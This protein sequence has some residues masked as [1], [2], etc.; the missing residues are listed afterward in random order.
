MKRPSRAILALTKRR[1]TAAL[2]AV[3]CVAACLVM[4][5]TAAAP[6]S[7]SPG[8]AHPARL[9]RAGHAA[10]VRPASAAQARPG[11]AGAWVA[12]DGSPG[13]PAV[14][15]ST[16]TLYVP[17]QC[18]ANHCM[19]STPAHVVD[20]VST[21][22]CNVKV[23]S[24]C[25][26]VA[27]ARVGTGPGA[28]VVDGG[29]DTVYVTNGNSNTVSVLNGAL[30]N[31]TVT[32][33]CGKPVATVKVGQFPV[34][35]VLNPVTGTV[36]VAS[37][38]GN[39]FVIDAAR[40]NAHTTSGCGQ[41]VKTVKVRPGAQALDVDVATNTVY[42]ANNGASGNGDT[43]SMIDGS[44][45]NGHDGR[46]CG[47][48]PHTVKVGSGAFWVAVDQASH[49]VYVANF[50]NGFNQGSVSVID[51]ARCNA[52]ITSGCRRIPPAVPT[53]IAASFVAVDS[54]LHTVFAVNHADNTLS[55]I[56]IR[57]CNGKV[58]S[59][60]RQRPPSQQISPDQGPGF[61]FFPNALALL[62]RTGTAYTM[63]V[64]GS[65]VLDVL[66]ISRCNAINTSGC[67]AEAPSVAGH[68][69][70]L[71]VDPATDTI[72]AG[73]LSRPRIDVLNGATCQHARLGGCVPVAAIPMGHPQANVG[74]IDPATHTLYASDP[75]SGT[76]SVINTANCN[77]IQTVG[78]AAQPPVIN[79][80]PFPNP[81]IVNPATQTLYVSYGSNA[82]RVAVVNAATCN[83]TR[84][85]GCGQTPAVVKV[86]KGTFNLAAS[87]AT[88]TIYAPNT[89]LDFDGDTVSVINGAACNGTDHSGCDHLAAV[90][91]AG[92]GPLGVTVNDR[93]HTVYVANNAHGYSPGTVS[94]INGA[95]CNGT[96]TAG[97]GRH[98]STMPTGPGPLFAA[99]DT[100]TGL[101]F[102][103]DFVG[104]TVTVLNGSR[105]NAQ[106]TS[107]CTRAGHAQPVGS[108]PQAIA[109]NQ[110]TRTVY[111]TNIYQPGSM[112]VFKDR[113]R[114]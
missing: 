77:A 112:S 37:P 102:V 100:R 105:C 53:G 3:S 26:V 1:L 38:D 2:G 25:R 67:R 4:A 109:V 113:R 81:P 17:I 15:P 90:A 27:R 28:A 7:A 101:L 8:A 21:A 71:S 86:G 93:T 18:V 79:V 47:Q 99:M 106:I 6:A 96:H 62:P 84:A 55:A 29:T 73:N 114:G 83:A 74:A 66:S 69:F 43:V 88:N 41:P 94:V 65:N 54:M 92:L 49:T 50:G 40:C 48:V 39:V 56:N 59:G 61:D 10:L 31:A 108:G 104:A 75:F 82:N 23:H 87:T 45:C 103:T 89:G 60:C 80:G 36:Y 51:G 22:K 64:G 5:A 111:V 52:R 107:G 76:V 85:T 14:N 97:C 34:A 11:G 20:I 57:T 44:T 19:P 13:T 30:C 58:T 35:A 98:F 9:D 42:T 12:L 24:G 46:G 110:R 78:C 72:Y 68:E 16:S 33:G 95:A 91:K 63:N 32:R 70:L